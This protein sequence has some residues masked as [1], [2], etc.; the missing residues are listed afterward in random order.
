MASKGTKLKDKLTGVGSYKGF[1]DAFVE[2]LSNAGE[3]GKHFSLAF[4]D[5]DWFKKVN[6]EFGHATAD[7][8]LVHIAEELT[9]TVPKGGLVY[10]Y[11]GD[12]FAVLMPGIGKEEAFLALESTR[13]AFKKGHILCGKKKNIKVPVSLSVGV[14]SYPYDGEVGQ[15]L[16]RKTGDAL[17]RAKTGGRSKV[18]LAREEKMVTKTSHY[19]QGQ[20]ERLAQ[21]AKK[22]GVGEAVLLREALDDLMRKYTL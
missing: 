4:V 14:A 9:R 5:I 15:D 16:I 11:G 10:R 13:K 8:V 21:L 3:S 6:D 19:T 22:E 7:E 17:Y 1:Q 2:I 18:C 20:L 12:E